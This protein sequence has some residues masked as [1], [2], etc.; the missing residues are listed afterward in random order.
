MRGPEV[1]WE[2]NPD[3][4]RE[5]DWIEPVYSTAGA[6]CADLSLQRKFIVPAFSAAAVPLDIRFRVRE[7]WKAL[8]YPRSSLLLMAGLLAPVSVIDGDYMTEDG[9]SGYVTLP[10]YNTAAHDTELHRGARVC[11]IEFMP[12]YATPGIERL[13]VI[14]TGG[15]GSTGGM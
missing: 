7:G 3:A 1:R 6:A 9:F 11:Q 12:A 14:R 15:L 13:R 4:V 5:E 8:I 10:V 2:C